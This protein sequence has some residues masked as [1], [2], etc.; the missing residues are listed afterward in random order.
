IASM[1]VFIESNAYT[2][3]Q[4]FVFDCERFV[5]KLRLLNEEKSKV[6]LRANEMI[7][8]VKNEVDS[9]K[10]CF[11]CY[12]SH[13]RRNWKDANGKSDEKLW[14]LIPC[15]PPHELQRSFKVV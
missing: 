15:E 5:Y 9:I 10:D 12:V 1:K 6:I 8:F 11:D 7:K 14:F 2:S 13:F 4:E 3:L